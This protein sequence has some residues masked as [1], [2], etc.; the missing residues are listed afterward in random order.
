MSQ[1]KPNTTVAAIIHCNGKFLMVEEVDNGQVV[2]NQPAGHVEAGETIY[3]AFVREVTEE[4]GLDVR[5]C[6]ISG[7][8]YNYRQDNQT[9]Y[10]RFCFIVELDSELVS[11]PNDS[12]IIATHWMSYEQI[13]NDKTPLRSVMVKK[14]LD[15][16]KNGAYY[17]LDI[18][19]E[20]LS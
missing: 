17:S 3:Q 5:P 16:Y 18:L 14:C 8:Y 4:T 10:V 1:F 13:T 12:D 19:Q 7:I 15:D 6:A 20:D 11:V 9:Y 2:F